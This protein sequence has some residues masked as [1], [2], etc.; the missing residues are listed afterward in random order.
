M[1]NL[2]I[3][4]VGVLL[5]ALSRN[6][7]SVDTITFITGA[8]FIIPGILNAIA[9]AREGKKSK[10]NPEGRSATS[11]TI[12]FLTCGGAVILGLVMCF[13]PGTFKS[14]FVFIFGLILILGGLFHLYMIYRGLRPAVMPKWL[15]ALPLAM[16]VGGV[17]MILFIEG[18][19][20]AS[21]FTGIGCVL[22]SATTIIELIAWRNYTRSQK[23]ME[24]SSDSPRLVEDVDA[25]EA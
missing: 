18:Q 3:L 1:A 22:Y 6:P 7:N 19:S 11:R 23:R 14:L 21:I 10:E 5:I 16:T 12:G 15:F 24:N 9:I 13:S 8:A 2:V 4:I 17:L 20:T 25:K